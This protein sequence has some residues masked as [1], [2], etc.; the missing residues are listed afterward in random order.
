MTDMTLKGIED[1]VKA[2]LG[3]LQDVIK[4]AKGEF[5]STAEVLKSKH[6]E[7]ETEAKRYGAEFGE[8][9]A[10]VT[11]IAGHMA[12]TQEKMQKA[13]AA[14]DKIT[15][16]LKAP[17][18]APGSD[19]IVKSRYGRKVEELTRKGHYDAFLRTKHFGEDDQA[20]EFDSSAVTD[21]GLTAY[22]KASSLF[23]NKVMRTPARV[24][25]VEHALT[26]DEIKALDPLLIKKT[27]STIS[28][29]SRYWLTNEMYG[30][31]I[32]CYDE[33]TDLSRLFSQV[34]ISRGA[35][36]VMKD[37]DVEKRAL[38]KCEID[39]TPGRNPTPTA[40]GTVIIQTHE[41][42]DQECITH[43]ML[44]D[45]EIN[46]ESWLV[47]RVAEGFSRGRNEKFMRGTG[48]NE[49]EGLLRPGKHIEMPLRSL[50]GSPAGQFTWKHL[51]IMPFQVAKKF[52]AQGSYMFA[53]DALMSLF[54]MS[55]GHGKPLI[56]N[57]ITVGADGIMRLWGYPL[58]QIDQL[59]N[60]QDTDGDPVVDA[61]PIGFGAWHAA[62][63]V[64]DRK[65]FFVIRDPAYN[66][67]GVTWHFGQRTGGGV[68]CENASTFLKIT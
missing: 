58:V 40:P 1:A 21:D 39:C 56:D 12:D 20:K 52:Q 61:K 10:K 14:I 24:P 51:R 15:A 34:A 27:I 19:Q 66:P 67:C 29:G 57:H 32:A 36:E 4:A 45:S 23:W 35:I 16:E 22:Q 42:Y 60:Y 41:L 68:L 8:T 48:V 53:R 65:G 25:M 55:D 33:V 17:R 38:F 63:L 5:H 11:E 7:L 9:K 62:Y 54:T 26:S 31:I 37:N 59:D 2:N 46:L 43:T 3:E 44:E 50:D 6:A 64:V 28:H 49:P 47:P 18:G 13:I 30:E